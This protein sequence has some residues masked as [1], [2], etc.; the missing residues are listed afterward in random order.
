MDRIKSIPA[1]FFFLAAA[2]VLYALFG[3]PTP[4]DPG[5]VEAAIGVLLILAVIWGGA[6]LFIGVAVRHVDPLTYV[7]LRLTI[8]AGA[9]WLFLK[10]KGEGLGLPREPKL[11]KV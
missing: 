7:W 3:S 11:A 6:F 5:A 2:I 9:M 10:W 1:S 4:D 8:A